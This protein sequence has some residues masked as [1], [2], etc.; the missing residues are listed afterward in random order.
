LL[1]PKRLWSSLG[2]VRSTVVILSALAVMATAGTLSPDG[3]ALIFA[4]WPFGLASLALALA[5]VSCFAGRARSLAARLGALP[6]AGSLILHFGIV[7]LICGLAATSWLS[8]DEYLWIA[9]GRAG[10]ALGVTVAVSDFEIQYHTDLSPRQYITRATIAAATAAGQGAPPAAAAERPVEIMVNRPANAG[11][12]LIY[13][14]G[15]RWRATLRS[16]AVAD[17]DGLGGV[18]AVEVVQRQSVAW[19][20]THLYLLLL[21]FAALPGDEPHASVLVHDGARPLGTWLLHQGE[22]RQLGGL[23][24]ELVAWG[25]E[26]GLAVRR[27]PGTPVVAVGGALLLV[28]AVMRLAVPA[29]RSRP[30]ATPAR[31]EAEA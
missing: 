2:T 20:G 11:G 22:R 27:D 16:G 24:V 26:T 6:T 23:W 10:S 30:Q 15:Y 13:Q 4:S 25:P 5:I 21:E 9:P 31:E 18:Q 19:P 1:H 28:G 17:S 3:G 29:L 12:A 14:A 8:Q 7:L